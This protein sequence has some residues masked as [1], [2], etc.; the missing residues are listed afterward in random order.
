MAEE[1]SEPHSSM[2]S[3]VS[4]SEEE[5][6]VPSSPDTSDSEDLPDCIRY[7]MLREKVEGKEKSLQ[8][9]VAH[10]LEELEMA[11]KL[12]S[13]AEEVKKVEK[14]GQALKL[15]EQRVKKLEEA[16]QAKKQEAAGLPAS[17]AAAVASQE[18]EL[19]KA[20]KLESWRASF[21]KIQEEEVQKLQK[22]E[23]AGSAKKQEAAGPPA[24]SDAADAS[25]KDGGKGKA[26]KKG[27]RKQ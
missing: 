27:N 22:L 15:Q 24:L 3:L 19:E 26:K 2:P 1:D 20:K 12:A 7:I 21:K 25:A 14:A 17:S 13:L 6:M 8:K 9:E 4:S 18:E 16:G 10:K 23:E 11:M 5:P